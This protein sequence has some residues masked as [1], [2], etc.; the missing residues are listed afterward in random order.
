LRGLGPRRSFNERSRLLE[1]S[2]PQ[3]NGISALQL[4]HELGLGS[5]KTA[6]LLCA[7]LR[8]SMVV[9]DQ[10]PLSGTV[11]IDKT[12][13]P[14]HGKNGSVTGDGWSRRGKMLV[15]GAVEVQ[16]LRLGSIRLSTVP[17]CSATGLHAF[18]AANLAPGATART[19]GR[20]GDWGA[21]GIN[22]VPQ[23]NVVTAGHN[24]LHW[25]R[26]VFSD[27]EVWALGVPHGLRREHLQSYLDEFV[28]RFNSRRARD[29]AFTALLGIA[30]AH[31]PVTYKMLVSRQAAA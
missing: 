26:H 17:D 31:Q 5:Y 29:A 8:R 23:F 13:I 28:F 7:K 3:P 21:L 15:L 2:R 27:L 22:H 6:W 14:C 18:L 4:Q 24:G 1:R 11:E 20:L 30:A 16:D 12:E 19:D 25:I 9:A 10:T